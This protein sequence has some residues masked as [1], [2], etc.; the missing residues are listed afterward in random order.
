MSKSEHRYSS[1]E[2]SAVFRMVEKGVKALVKNG[3]IE[4]KT[5][6]DHIV[7]YLA[8]LLTEAGFKLVSELREGERVL[9][10]VQLTSKKH[11]RAGAA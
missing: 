7:G 2:S 5:S 8:K 6:R 4:E 10:V 11:A 1:L 3:D 9:R